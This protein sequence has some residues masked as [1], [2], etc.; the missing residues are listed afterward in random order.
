MGHVRALEQLVASTSPVYLPEE[1]ISVLPGGVF[2]K[3]IWPSLQ[4]A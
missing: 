2:L 3:W 1:R 4:V